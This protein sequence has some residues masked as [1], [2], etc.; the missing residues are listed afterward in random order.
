MEHDPR[1]PGK[2]DCARTLLQLI[3]GVTKFTARR[4][5]GSDELED[6][7]VGQEQD[8]EPDRDDR[9]ADPSEECAFDLICE[10]RWRY[11]LAPQAWPWNECVE[12][13]STPVFR[14]RRVASNKELHPIEQPGARCQYGIQG[15]RLVATGRAGSEREVSAHHAS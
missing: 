5:V 10:G 14:L 3:R 13:A 8:T 4:I 15:Y 2:N 11:D 6:S 12:V 1:S 7:V 9:S